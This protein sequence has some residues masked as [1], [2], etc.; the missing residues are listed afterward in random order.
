MAADEHHE[1][2]PGQQPTVE[3]GADASDT[4]LEEARRHLGRHQSSLDG[5]GAILNKR[6]EH[7]EQFLRESPY[8]K[9]VKAILRDRM[10]S[11]PTAFNPAGQIAIDKIAGWVEIACYG[12]GLDMRKGVVTGLMPTFTAN[13]SSSDFFGTGVA[14]VGLDAGVLVFTGALSKLLARTI[15]WTGI[16]TYPGFDPVAEAAV[17]RAIDNEQLRTDWFHFFARFAGIPLS[18]DF[19]DTDIDPALERHAV[20]LMSALEVYVV[21]H[22]YGH[23]IHQH[24]VGA[25]SAASIAIEEA[26]EMEYEADRIAIAISTFLGTMGFAG[27]GYRRVPNLWMESGGSAVAYLVAA[28]CA[29]RL[30]DI[31]NTGDYID[32]PSPTHPPT[33]PRLRKMED[34]LRPR[35]NLI[36]RAYIV[37]LIRGIFNRFL[38]AFANMHREGIRPVMDGFTGT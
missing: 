38:P 37:M 18:L 7:F 34:V 8:D 2:N 14:I 9:S 16:G 17:Q 4:D 35:R 3:P 31:L 21:G 30:K 23:H 11:D 12:L 20:K 15:Q 32:I 24:S 25:A 28:D 1:D 22:E 5:T 36:F 33:D 27:D 6:R 29:R 19:S 10:V 13:A 26:Y